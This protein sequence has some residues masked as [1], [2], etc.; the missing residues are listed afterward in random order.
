MCTL[1][2]L[3]PLV[4]GIDCEILII[5]TIWYIWWER[6]QLVHGEEVQSPAR[7]ALSISALAANYTHARKKETG[8]KKE[9][10]IK[11]MEGCVK[12]NVDATFH[13]ETLSGAVGAVLRDDRGGFIA[14]SNEKLEHVVDAATAEV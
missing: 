12:L 14:A 11:P 10:W 6:R 3:A 2:G 4:P 9:R 8:V 5:T 1:N 13:V 7:S